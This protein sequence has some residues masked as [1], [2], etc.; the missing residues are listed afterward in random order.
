M[1]VI[2]LPGALPLG[3]F[4]AYAWKLSLGGDSP[5]ALS[6]WVGGYLVEMVAG[7]DVLPRGILRRVKWT[8]IHR[9]SLNY[10]F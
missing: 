4:A 2:E 6:G 1:G 10:H 5:D 3:D 9:S 8:P 7:G